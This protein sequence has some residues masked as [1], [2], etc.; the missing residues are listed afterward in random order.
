MTEV[1]AQAHSH[2]SIHKAQPDLA[3]PDLRED[4]G[5]SSH[6][7]TPK[8]FLTRLEPIYTRWLLVQKEVLPGEGLETYGL[9]RVHQ[10]KDC[11]F[12]AISDCLG[13]RTPA[14]LDSTRQVCPITCESALRATFPDICL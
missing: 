10:A 12:N 5:R 2:R 11:Y 6:V 4:D 9:V 3:M 1:N 13:P 14:A 7:Y 8:S